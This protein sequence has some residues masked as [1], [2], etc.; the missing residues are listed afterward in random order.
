MRWDFIWECWARP[1]INGFSFTSPGSGKN[2]IQIYLTESWSV[3]WFSF[4]GRGI[5]DGLVSIRSCYMQRSL[6]SHI[7]FQ[8]DDYGATLKNMFFFDVILMNVWPSSSLLRVDWS[9]PKH[10][11]FLQNFG[12]SQPLSFQLH[13]IE[14]TLNTCL[15]QRPSKQLELSDAQTGFKWMTCYLFF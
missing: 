12:C 8:N 9:L 2:K 4:K 15:Q 13:Y 6:T 5:H 3:L 10:K 7:P 11:K 1:Q 14:T